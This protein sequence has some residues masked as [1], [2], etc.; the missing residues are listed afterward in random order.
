MKSILTLLLLSAVSCFG[1]LTNLIFAWDASAD[2]TG[3]RFY[4]VQGTNRILLGMT[5]ATTF[6]VSNWNVS[7]SRTVTVTATN[8]LGETLPA[9]SLVVPPSP[10]TPLNLK[11]IP[12]SIVSP[13]PGVLELSTDLVDWSQRFRLALGPTSGAVQVTWIR[14]PTEPMVFMRSRLSVPVSLPPLP[15]I[16]PPP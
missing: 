13:V 12:L 1:Q 8:M 6:T 9:P 15:T 4:E 16:R 14:Y 5:A 2:A 11:P 3:Y 10:K 7:T